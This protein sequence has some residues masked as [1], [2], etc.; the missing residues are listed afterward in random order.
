MQG[1]LREIRVE[2]TH[3][4]AGCCWVVCLSVG[5]AQ[6]L[7]NSISWF[8]GMPLSSLVSPSDRG[9]NVTAAEIA[10]PWTGSRRRQVIT[11]VVGKT[12]LVIPYHTLLKR[13]ALLIGYT[14]QTPTSRF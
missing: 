10:E 5:D 6:R 13:T 7:S 8:V 2:H 4:V 1:R 12:L 14:I 9:E 11:L 3:S